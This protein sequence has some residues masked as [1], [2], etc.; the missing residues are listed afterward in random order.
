MRKDE[1]TGTLVALDASD[2]ALEDDKLDHEDDG[3]AGVTDSL[4]SRNHTEEHHV[5]KH[6]P[7]LLWISY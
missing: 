3:T 1:S 7:L 4:H 5:V 6:L 2:E